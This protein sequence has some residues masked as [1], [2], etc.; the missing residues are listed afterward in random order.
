M[1][2]LILAHV[3]PEWL[4]DYAQGVQLFRKKNSQD[5]WIQFLKMNRYQMPSSRHCIDGNAT[6]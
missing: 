4:A 3:H 2:V 5:G 1:N 6:F